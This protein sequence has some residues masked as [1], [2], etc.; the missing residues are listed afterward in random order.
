MKSLIAAVGIALLSTITF[1]QS[2]EAPK[3]SL[4]KIEKV[5][6]EGS[7]A[8]IGLMRQ[9]GSQGYNLPLLAII[10]NL[11]PKTVRY[12]FGNPSNGTVIELVATLGEDF[13]PV[14]T[15]ILGSGFFVP[16]NGAAQP[17]QTAPVNP[18]VAPKTED[19]PK[20]QE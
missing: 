10:T 16:L 20:D 4:P 5:C 14:K 19:E 7:E 13:K 15:C 6:V 17:Q 11:E 3:L 1:A 8:A 2:Q 12:T 9:L 18:P